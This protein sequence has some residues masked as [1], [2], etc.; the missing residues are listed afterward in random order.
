MAQSNL[1]GLYALAA[2]TIWGVAPVYF[3]LVGFAQPMEV[4]A[5][6]IFWSVPL[7][8][9]IVSLVRDWSS[10]IG[11]SVREY[12]FLFASAMCLAVN[13]LV[14]IIAISEEKI[15]ETSL[16]YF[17]NPLISIFLGWVFLRER[18][19]LL[20]WFA[21]LIAILGVLWE[22]Y[23]DRLI[24]VYGLAL[25]ISFGIYGLLRKQVNLPAAPGLL[26]E[27]SFL[28][29]LVLLYVL[30]FSHT[31]ELRSQGEFSL[32]MFGGVMTVIPLLFFTA[33]TTRLPLVILGVFQYLA[34]SLSLIIAIYAYGETVSS[35]RWV[36]L[37]SVW[38]ALVIFSVDGFY[39]FYR[40]RSGPRSAHRHS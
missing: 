19:T 36:T 13:W 15:V 2:M 33:A 14:F 26:V 21:V 35:T 25:A 11:L 9:L 28:I 18:L 4:L 32:L 39:R 1:G 16:G 30:F 31:S 23:T 27:C 37:L 29:P 7:L 8:C 6:R 17:I 34:P 24:P 5:H 22:L 40:S 12:L 3:V 38:A 20:Q 10:V